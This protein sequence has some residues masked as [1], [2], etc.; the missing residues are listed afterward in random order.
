MVDM[1]HIVKSDVST[2]GNRLAAGNSPSHILQVLVTRRQLSIH[3]VRIQRAVRHVRE[4]GNGQLLVVG[5]VRHDAESAGLGEAGGGAGVGSEA[6]PEAIE[7]EALDA[8]AGARDR[9]RVGVEGE[10]A[11]LE[12]VEGAGGAGLL[13]C[14]VRDYGGEAVDWALL[15]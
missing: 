9:L 5:G 1:L 15:V 11:E 6:E 8:G 12:E 3:Q 2:L 4:R 7:I 14:G 10:L 13:G